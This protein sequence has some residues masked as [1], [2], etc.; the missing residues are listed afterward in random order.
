VVF[1]HPA[2][3]PADGSRSVGIQPETKKIALGLSP[4][5]LRLGESCGRS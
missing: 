4:A 3:N 2:R 1:P 5:I